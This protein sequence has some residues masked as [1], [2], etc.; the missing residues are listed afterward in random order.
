MN[1]KCSLEIHLVH[2]EVEINRSSY[3]L[4]PQVK[5]FVSSL[6]KKQQFA[7]DTK[8]NAIKFSPFKS[9]QFSQM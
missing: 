8:K 5:Y 7:A 4:G 2:F 3:I 1:I 6:A 9:S